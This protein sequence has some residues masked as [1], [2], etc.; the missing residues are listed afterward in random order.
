LNKTNNGVMKMLIPTKP[1]E[2]KDITKAQPE[3]ETLKLCGKSVRAAM[4]FAAKN[5]VRYYLNG[6]F[7]DHR[8]Y[9]VATDGHTMIRIENDECKR[10]TK[11]LIIGIR[12]A[13]LPAKSMLVELVSSDYKGGFV[14]FGRC[15]IGDI[16]DARVF[17]VIDGNYPDIDR[18]IPRSPLAAIERIVINPKYIARVGDAQT[19]LIGSRVTSA[20]FKFR[21]N[22]NAIEVDIAYDIKAKIILMPCIV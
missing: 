20:E 18:V 12:G 8:G 3:F 22:D 1:L 4:L 11:S 21:G 17:E 16:E 10:L 19:I 9:I 6:I 13:K 15:S 7:L 5:D 2:Y 14:R